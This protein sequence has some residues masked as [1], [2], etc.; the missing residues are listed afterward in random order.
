[1]LGFYALNHGEYAQA[2]QAFETLLSL[3][4]KNPLAYNRVAEC[5]LRGGEPHKALDLLKQA[6]ELDPGIRS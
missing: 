5:L 1:M 3:E 6:L 2:K 4:P